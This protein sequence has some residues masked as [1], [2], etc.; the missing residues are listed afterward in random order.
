MLL[1]FLLYCK[2]TQS[3][4]VSSAVQQGPLV[5]P[6][7]MQQFAPEAGKFG[8]FFFHWFPQ[9]LSIRASLFGLSVVSFFSSNHCLCL[10]LMTDSSK[11]SFRDSIFLSSLLLQM[12]PQCQY[13]FSLVSISLDLLLDLPQSFRR[14]Q[15]Q[16]LKAGCAH[17]SS[18]F[19]FLKSMFSLNKDVSVTQIGIFLALPLL[20][21]SFLG[22]KLSG[23]QPFQLFPQR[24]SEVGQQQHDLNLEIFIFLHCFSCLLPFLV[25]SMFHINIH[26]CKFTCR[27]VCH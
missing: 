25:S 5:Q 7:Q 27:C 15:Y 16:S 26:I 11:C 1:Q 23:E 2:V 13:I 17:W 8:L 6:F 19:T 21:I 9:V 4:T 14:T 3:H 22:R 12:K 10:S 24:L 20:I 18:K